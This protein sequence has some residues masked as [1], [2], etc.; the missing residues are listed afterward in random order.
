MVET[1]SASAPADQQLCAPPG[2]ESCAPTNVDNTDNFCGSSLLGRTDSSLT[3]A[4]RQW[5][6]RYPCIG[7]EQLAELREAFLMFAVNLP[8]MTPRTAATVADSARLDVADIGACL[9]AVGQN[10]S[11]ADV[12]RLMALAVAKQQQQQPEDVVG[13]SSVVPSS[14][15]ISAVSSNRAVMAKLPLTGP[16]L[17]PGTGRVLAAASDHAQSSRPS[18]C[19]SPTTGVSQSVLPMSAIKLRSIMFI[20][21]HLQPDVR[22]HIYRYV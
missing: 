21:V 19:Q 8:V 5:L 13:L 3:D 4:E 20:V 2:D 12:A 1:E 15:V 22:R 16:G 14:Q 10:P 17:G 11:Q 18:I 7:R 6:S 9:R